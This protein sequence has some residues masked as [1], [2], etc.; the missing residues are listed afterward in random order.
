MPIREGAWDCPFCG[1]T[2]NRGPKKHCGGCGAPRGAD[3]RFYVPD[4]SPEVRDA[5]A[6]KRAAAG[7]DWSCAH[8]GGDN[9]AGD[10][11][12]SGCGASRDGSKP[13]AVVEHR[14]GDPKAPAPVPAPVRSRPR[15]TWWLIG[16]G[17]GL[18]AALGLL[19]LLGG[20][21]KSALTVTGH[22]WTRTVVVEEL[23]TVTESAW[24]GEVPE[25]AR[26]L[27]A[28]NEVHHVNRVRVGTETKTRTV[29]ERVQTGTERV[30]VGTRDL[31]NGYF[32]DVFE[33]RPTY[34]NRSR[35]E[36]YQEPIYREQPVYKKRL[37]YEIERWRP[38][39]VARA[40]GADLS[41]AWPD[42]QLGARERAGARSA[43]Y[44]VLFQDK[45]GRPARHAAEDEQLWRSFAAG[46]LVRGRVDSKGDAPRPERSRR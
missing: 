45:K 28:S 23:H 21:G 34:A 15:R 31:G 20:A 14:P 39:R 35:E 8:C 37:R 5:E 11:C 40:E 36:T 42:P 10:R 18:P 16:I 4:D 25:G 2:R 43:S 19:I 22:R 26:I 17:L 9:P 46:E 44:D 33:D 1:R 6:L 24:E 7:P 27:A 32:E 12:C 3:V 38:G 41:P 13:R 30:R 29:T